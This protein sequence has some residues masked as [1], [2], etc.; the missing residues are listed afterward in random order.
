MST[1]N[2]EVIAS[3]LTPY[4][5]GSYLAAS[6]HDLLRAIELYDW[7]VAVSGALHEDLGRLEVVFRNALD[8]AL[9][10]LGASRGWPAVWY[11]RTQL[12]TGKHSR[13]VR[14]GIAVARSR[15][16][17]SGRPEVHGKVIAELSFGFWRYLCT[18]PYLTS[19]WVP[20]LAAAFP[21]HPDVGNPFA[22]RRAVDDRMQ[23]LHFL[24]NRIAHHEPIH[25]RNLA[26]D[27]NDLLRL[28]GWICPDARAWV[29]RTSGC[30]TVLAHRPVFGVPGGS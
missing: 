2:Y 15:A 17:R 12:F 16:S 22:V 29:A 20:A 1:I 26:Q 27:H 6:G 18:R 25:Q 3:R 11:R 23:R 30:C 10:Q 13:R 21:H 4:R 7:N 5:L 19:L 8:A 14:E 28:A 24:R 9:V